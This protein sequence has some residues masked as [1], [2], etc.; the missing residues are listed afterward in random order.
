[1]WY[2]QEDLKSISEFLKKSSLGMS[3]KILQNQLFLAAYE[4]CSEAL[5]STKEGINKLLT[6]RIFQ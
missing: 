5:I 4:K 3:G 6:G 2:V 1:M